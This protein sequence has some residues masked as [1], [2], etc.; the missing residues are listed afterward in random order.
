MASGKKAISAAGPIPPFSQSLKSEKAE[1]EEIWHILANKDFVLFQSF[2]TIFLYDY[3][4]VT[5]LTPPGNIMFVQ[6]I[7]DRLLFQVLDKGLY[8]LLPGN[9]FRFVEG[10]EILAPTTVSI[11]LPLFEG[12]FLAGTNNHG[13]FL[14]R[15]G[16]F[17][18]WDNPLNAQLKKTQLNKG[19]VLQDGGLALGTILDGLF[20][21]NPDGTPRFHLSQENGLQN[22]TVLALFEDQDHNLWVGLDKGIDLVEIRSPLTYYTDRLGKTGTIYSAA[23]FEGQLYLGTNQGVFYK[24][25]PAEKGTFQLVEGT[26]GQVWELQVFDGQLLCGHNEGT[27]L[28][29]DR[30]SRKISSIKGGWRT[31]RHPE[32]SDLLVQGSYNGIV[33]FQKDARGRW[34]FSHRVDGFLEPIKEL[35]FD[36]AGNLWAVHSHRGLHRIKLGSNALRVEEIRHFERDSGLPTEFNVHIFV[37]N[38]TFVIHSDTSFFTFREESQ[39]LEPIAAINHIPLPGKSRIHPG[40]N[41]DWFISRENELDYIHEG[42]VH[43]LEVQLVPG[44]EHIVSLAN[45]LYLFCLN[46][47]Y[48]LLRET[49]RPHLKFPQEIHPVLRTVEKYGKNGYR[50]SVACPQFTQEALFR[51]KLDGYDPGWTSWN[52]ASIKEYMNLPPGNYQFHVQSNCSEASSVF[53]FT[54]P[55]PWYLS[56]WAALLYLLIGAGLGWGLY[57]IS[58]RRLSRQL[59]KL[60]TEK[61]RE[62]DKER[63]KASNERLHMEISSKN[64]ELANSTMNLIR[65]NETLSKIKAALQKLPEAEKPSRELKKLLRLIDEHITSDHDWELLEE[66]FNHVHG[67]FFKK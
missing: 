24:D 61:M 13:I 54:I 3:E 43:R 27:F 6:Q 51:Y 66:S 45:G 41:T 18:P 4:K 29:E 26:Q 10:S 21:L 63:M 33:I 47:G 20:V 31:L 57:L 37:L 19:L 14:Y 2:S 9:S 12:Q 49:D 15:N 23:L 5:I 39:S 64:N 58:Q 17:T 25:W 16:R 56:K 42:I 50:F 35:C 1:T 65:K 28:I 46:D 22:N 38:D 62:L 60:E 48:A 44:D 32:R 40:T 34:E 53:S 7:E 30:K 36:P 59:R 11:L 8:E 55:P 67:N 52:P